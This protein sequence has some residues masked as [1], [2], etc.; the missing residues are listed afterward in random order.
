MRPTTS[1][2]KISRIL[3]LPLIPTVIVVGYGFAYMLIMSGNL[4]KALSNPYPY[5]LVPLAIITYLDAL[6]LIAIWLLAPA[7]FRHLRRYLEGQTVTRTRK[8]L[9]VSG[10]LLT[11]LS[12][13]GVLALRLMEMDRPKLRLLEMPLTLDAGQVKSLP[14]SP[15]ATYDY[16]ITLN[17]TASPEDQREMVCSLGSGSDLPFSSFNCVGHSVLD[18]SWTL[19]R[20]DGQELRGQASDWDRNGTELPYDSIDRIIGS[21]KGTQGQRYVL[22][23]DVGPNAGTLRK[24]SPLLVVQAWGGLGM[25]YAFRI[26]LIAL[27]S[28]IAFVMA[29]ITFVRVWLIGQDAA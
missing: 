24:F 20:G 16:Q 29:A 22:N 27:A 6:L 2:Q 10:T 25:R 26:Q 17:F 19:V 7:A 1:R 18:V 5:W 14:F 11:I 15:D 23:L 9:F 8:L 28:I 21:F 3:L 13:S 12:L 4:H